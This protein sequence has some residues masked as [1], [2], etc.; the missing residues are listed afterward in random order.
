[1]LQNRKHSINDADCLGPASTRLSALVLCSIDG[2]EDSG[3]V[4]PTVILYFNV[5]DSTVTSVH[6]EWKASPRSHLTLLPPRLLLLSIG[7][8]FFGS[9]SLFLFLLS[10]QAQGIPPSKTFSAIRSLS[11]PCQLIH[12]LL[13]GADYSSGTL[14]RSKEGLY[15]WQRSRPSSDALSARTSD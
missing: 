7:S 9:P 14:G 6:L 15:E 8:H 13:A 10:L 4:N 3:Y 5:M 2:D 12:Q 1:M 11:F